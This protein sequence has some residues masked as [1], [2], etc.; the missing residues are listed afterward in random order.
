[1]CI[2]DQTVYYTLSTIAQ[3]QAAVVA[4]LGVFLFYKIQRISDIQIGQGKAIK[5]NLDEKIE[6]KERNID[7]HYRRLRDAIHRKN[8]YGIEEAV[9][10][11]TIEEIKAAKQDLATNGYYLH[12]Y[13]KFIDT[14][15][16]LNILKWTT[17]IALTLC[18]TSL[19]YS[20]I[21]LSQIDSI[22][23]YNCIILSNVILFT[24]AE[25]FSIYVVINSLFKI[26]PFEKDKVQEDKKLDKELKKV[27]CEY[28]IRRNQTT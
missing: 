6:K 17:A 26:L 18:F 4:L 28:D 22:N 27:L 19:L 15:R 2:T 20:L 5:A 10:H 7:T 11:F 25:V 21:S 24:V 16:T 23:N 9:L 3:V 12:V 1:M 14:K 13:P 8:L